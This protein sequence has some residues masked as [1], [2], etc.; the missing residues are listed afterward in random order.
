VYLIAEIDLQFGRIGEFNE[1]MG[2]IVPILEREGW[3]LEAAYISVVGRVGHVIDIFE[4]P[5]A[6][7][8]TSVQQAVR[9]NPEFTSL[10]AK[11]VDIIDEERT[12]LAVRT[13]YGA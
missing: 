10:M 7:T 9:A 13:P 6:N 4:V 5:D 8:V 3:R 2:R 11:F 1:I 12:M